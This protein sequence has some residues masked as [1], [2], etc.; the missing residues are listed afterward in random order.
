MMF[1]F[2]HRLS[3]SGSVN[4]THAEN[5]RI[6]LYKRLAFALEKYHDTRHTIVVIFTLSDIFK[7]ENYDYSG[8]DPDLYLDQSKPERPDPIPLLAWNRCRS[9]GK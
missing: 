6:F 4:G 7:N 2:Y 5:L 3:D 9:Q 8:L 1:M